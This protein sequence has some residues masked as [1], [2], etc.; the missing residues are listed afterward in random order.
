MS[1]FPNRQTF[2]NTVHDFYSQSETDAG[3]FPDEKQREP[4]DRLNLDHW[5]E[6]NQK[7]YL[8][9]FNRGFNGSVR[10]IKQIV[11]EVRQEN[12]TDE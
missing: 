3:D 1:T 8:H 11:K 6:L 12:T 5:G 7:Y 10:A 2:R 4:L 9:N